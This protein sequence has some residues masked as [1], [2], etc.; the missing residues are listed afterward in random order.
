M[1]EMVIWNDEGFMIHSCVVFLSFF[2][3]FFAIL[4]IQ[5]SWSSHLLKSTLTWVEMLV[6]FA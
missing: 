2:N 1:R 3:F 4:Q 6:L 5:S